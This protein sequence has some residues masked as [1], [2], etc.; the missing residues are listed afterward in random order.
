[1]RLSF[2]V[3]VYVIVLF[4]ASLFA[5]EKL[6]VV[7]SF[8][9]L[10][11]IVANVGGD[12]IDMT[13]IVDADGDAHVYSPTPADARAIARAKLVFVNGLAFEGWLDRL[14]VASEYSGPV[15]EA[16]KGVIPLSMAEEG[17]DEH[18]K[19][20]HDEHAKEGHDEHAK[21]GHDEH[22]KEGHDE[23][24]KEGHDEHDHGGSDPH[25]WQSLANARVYVANIL[26]ALITSDPE[27]ASIYAANAASYLAKIDSTE[28]MVKAAVA[29][30]PK[31][32]RTIVTSHDAFG[33]FGAAYGLK[34]RAPVG[35]ST[36]AEA[37]AAD[38]AQL[39]SQIQDEKITAAFTENI[40]DPRLLKIIVEETDARIGGILYSDSLSKKVGPAA[41]YLD[42]MRH[43]IRT[44][45]SALSL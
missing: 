36:D 26:A 20:G 21:E 37:S 39:I 1:M 6:P 2:S 35:M 44:L 43:N 27:G 23:H 34:F 12:R 31:N 4:P 10:G 22:A 45:V 7:A 3:F 5:Q 41:T 15:I 32:R 28:A 18:A 13:T 40:T 8:S 14:I 33:Y 30:L 29:T 16:S 42:M 17:H 19:E 11:D 25:A 24:A 38:V 9:I